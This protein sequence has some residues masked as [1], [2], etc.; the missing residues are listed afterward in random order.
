MKERNASALKI[1]ASD[2][3]NKD[4]MN[5]FFNLLQNARE[6]KLSLINMTYHPLPVQDRSICFR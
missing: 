3:P 1:S 4:P 2:I 6:W 5:T